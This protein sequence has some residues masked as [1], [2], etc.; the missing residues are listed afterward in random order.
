MQLLR[1]L[2]HLPPELMGG[3]VAIGN[4]DGVHRGHACLIERLVAQARTVGGPVIVFTFD[5]HPLAILKPEWLPTPMTRSERKAELL[6][7]LGVDAVMAYPTDRA[8]LSL[9][10]QAFFDFVIR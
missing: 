7:Q 6:A 2:D 4:F 8:L 3:G 5:P 10:P 9:T 1:S